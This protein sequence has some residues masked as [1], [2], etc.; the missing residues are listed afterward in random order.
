MRVDP[1]NDI[2]NTT[3][4]P[5]PAAGT[6]LGFGQD[7]MALNRADALNRALEQTPA[8]RADKVAQAKD[9]MQD[10]TYPPLELIRRI[11]ALLAIHI[12]S[13]PSPE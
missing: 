8:V 11:S 6:A 13:P 10:G 4:I 1:S 7:R 5:G 2:V 12:Q 3:G 9:L